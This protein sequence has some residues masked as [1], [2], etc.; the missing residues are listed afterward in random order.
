MADIAKSL[1][2]FKSNFDLR[3]LIDSKLEVIYDQDIIN[4]IS[5]ESSW[6]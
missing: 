5:K 6:T 2:A 3:L 4:T 1:S